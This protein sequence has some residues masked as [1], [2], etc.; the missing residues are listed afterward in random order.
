MLRGITYRFALAVLGGALVVACVFSSL[1]VWAELQEVQVGGSIRLR[2]RLW[3]NTY[4]RTVGAP[5]EVRIT[6]GSVSRLAL[7]P[8]GAAS[9]YAFDNRELAYVEQGT[10]VYAEAHFSEDVS[11]RVEFEYFCLWGRHFRSDVFTGADTPGEAEV[12]LLQSYIEI[13]HAWNIPLQLRVGRQLIKLGKG[14]LIDDSITPTLAF[15]MDAVRATY[16]TERLTVD[17]FA[18][19]LVERS[20]QEKDGDTDLYGLYATYKVNDALNVSAYYF[21]LRDA[22][23]REQTRADVITEF[24]ED[25]LDIDQY[26]VTRLNTVGLRAFGKTTTWDYDLEL[27]YQ[28]GP[29]D[30]LGVE[31]RRAPWVY[32][33]SGAHFDAYAA[34]AEVGYTFAVKA[35][36]R[37]AL[38]GA[39][40]SAEDNRTVSFGEW[41]NPF[42]RPEAPTAFNRMFTGRA[43]S[44]VLDIL[45]DMSNFYQV[46]AQ[47]TAKPTEKIEVGLRLAQFWVF[48]PWEG[49]RYRLNRRFVGGRP[50]RAVLPF[51]TKESSNDIGFTTH[52][53]VRYDYSKD[54]FITVGWEHLFSGQALEDGNFL[55]K[56]GMEY[57]GGTDSKDADYVYV[58]TGI[59]F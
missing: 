40:F 45:Q 34:D 59:R 32:G 33:D 23:S 39:V 8:F 35:H 28:F 57:S 5:P 22:L 58:D 16:T 29:A 53:W 1:N 51:I 3:E 17:A 47:V 21:L 41:I 42:A 18:A 19:K 15:P 54:W 37:V 30:A 4:N 26:G 50:Q 14:W 24:L 2:A 48:D 9:R 56:N 43:Y 49:P 46:R 25:L 38:G 20:P 44:G 13:D 6:P 52:V 27:A 31:F 7:G 55:H 36:P 11:A 12:S 10:R